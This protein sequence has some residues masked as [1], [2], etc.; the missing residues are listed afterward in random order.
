V[1]LFVGVY[2][3]LDVRLY[4]TLGVPDH[5]QQ[6]QL[7]A[8]IHQQQFVIF[9]CQ[10]L[11]GEQCSKSRDFDSRICKRDCLSVCLMS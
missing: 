5:R 10:R 6:G 2:N 1:V 9:W 4:T 3:W 11:S 7:I 8:R